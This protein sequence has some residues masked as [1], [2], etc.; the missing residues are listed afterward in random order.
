MI[1]SAIVNA[2]PPNCETNN[3]NTCE[4]SS[5][6]AIYIAM[7][8]VLNK[9]NKVHHL[10][11]NTDEDMYPL[12]TIDVDGKPRGNKRLMPSNSTT[13]LHLNSLN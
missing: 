4:F 10:D 1:S 7:A 12:F 3:S 2:P 6:N 13:F 5:D 9:R 11:G 8:D